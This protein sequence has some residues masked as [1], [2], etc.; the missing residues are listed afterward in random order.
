MKNMKMR[1]FNILTKYVPLRLGLTNLALVLT[2]LFYL[3]RFHGKEGLLNLTFRANDIFIFIYSFITLNILIQL[4]NIITSKS[5][6]LWFTASLMLLFLYNILFSYHY[7]VKSSLDFAVIRDNFSDIFYSKSIITIVSDIGFVELSLALAVSAIFI[8]LEYKKQLISCQRQD[9]PLL[10][11]FIFMAALYVAVVIVPFT[12][13]DQITCFFKSA[14]SYYFQN[15]TSDVTYHPGTY[16][17]IKKGNTSFEAAPEAPVQSNRPNVF[18]IMI[19]SFNANFVE[20]KSPEGIEYTPVFNSHIKK[21]LYV[22]K[23][24]GNSIQTCKGQFAIFFSMIPSFKGKV[25]VNYPDTKFYS[26][27]Q[28]MRDNGYTTIFFQGDEDIN[29]DNSYSFLGKNG[30]SYVE[31]VKPMLGPGDKEFIWG[32]GVQDDVLYK[33]FFERLDRIHTQQKDKAPFFAGIA[34]ISNHMMFN[35][36]PQHLRKLYQQPKSWKE[37]Y[38][39]SINFTDSCLTQFFKELA[40]REYLQNSIVI[41]TGDHSFPVGEHNLYHNEASFF[42][43]FFRTPFLMVWENRLFPERITTIPYC[44]MDIA[45]TIVDLTKLTSERNHFEGVSMYGVRKIHPIYLIQPYSGGYIAVL[46]YPY[47]YIKPLKSEGKREM[48]FRLDHDPKETINL[49]EYTDNAVKLKNLQDKMQFIYLNQMLIEQNE[50]WLP[51]Q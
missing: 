29:L 43:E 3:I 40:S 8:I 24:Y 30:F 39:N 9:K 37:C 5:R 20:T 48:L 28:M 6:K 17:L 38:A 13:H 50:V 32:W 33:R 15:I 51:A 47:K 44:Q 22:E 31:S 21:G 26:L 2:Q 41:I 45:P 4:I 7:R 25:F 42:D 23:F 49:I 11:K 1:L 34:T 12:T 46:N 36:V 35:N 27:P 18:I 19:E 16:P 10:P 14:Y